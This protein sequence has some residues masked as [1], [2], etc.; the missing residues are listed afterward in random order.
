ME[1]AKHD[2]D[3][4]TRGGTAEIFQAWDDR[5][6]GR[7][8]AGAL[9]VGRVAEQGQHALVAVTRKSVEVKGSAAYWGLVDLE[10]AGVDDYA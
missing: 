5:A 2:E 1:E 7:G 3:Y 9:D 4:A 10:I 6:F 8:E